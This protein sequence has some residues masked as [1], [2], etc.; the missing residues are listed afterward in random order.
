VRAPVRRGAAAVR[1][2][3]GGSSG[4]PSPALVFAVP[5][6]GAVGLRSAVFAASDCIGR[7]QVCWCSLGIGWGA[8]ESLDGDVCGR[9]SLLGGV[10]LHPSAS[11]R[12]MLRVKT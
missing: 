4:L 5:S 10:L 6:A 9:R 1:P 11:P 7:G 2:G 8:G 12:R 3:G